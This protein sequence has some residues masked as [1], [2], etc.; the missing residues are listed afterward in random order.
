MAQNQYFSA[1]L[2][3]GVK[4]FPVEGPGGAPGSVGIDGFPIMLT[5]TG[6]K[7][8]LV[9]LK[10]ALALPQV[11]DG[12]EEED[13]GKSE[14]GLEETLGIVEVVSKGRRDGAVELSCEGD[15]DKENS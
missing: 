9:E 11:A 14:V 13:D 12:P 4:E 10:E 3:D 7:I 15:E 6:I 1:R 2:K 5:T 8:N